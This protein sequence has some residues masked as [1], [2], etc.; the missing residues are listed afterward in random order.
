MNDKLPLRSSKRR[1]N[2]DREHNAVH[3][4]EQLTTTQACEYMILHGVEVNPNI[5]ALLRRDGKGPRYLKIGHKV[6]YTPRFLDRFIESRRPRV[7][8]PAA[9]QRGK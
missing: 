4:D 9:R 7:I 5:L 1:A 8:D 3:P 6:R 2:G